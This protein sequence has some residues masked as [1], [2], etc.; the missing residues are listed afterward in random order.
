M[1]SNKGKIW[2]NNGVLEGMYDKPPK[3][4]EKGRIVK[5]ETKT[6]DVTE[7]VRQANFTRPKRRS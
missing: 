1:S 5:S 4:W 6:F 2:Y 3:G 7:K